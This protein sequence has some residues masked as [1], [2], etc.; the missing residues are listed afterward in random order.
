V[1]RVVEIDGLRAAAPIHSGVT[2]APLR[3]QAEV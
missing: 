3:R 2:A 1:N